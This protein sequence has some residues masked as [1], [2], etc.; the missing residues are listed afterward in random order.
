MSTFLEGVGRGLRS[1]YCSQVRSSPEWLQNVRRV[2]VPTDFRERA[3]FLNN[4]V[5]GDEGPSL[6]PPPYTGGQ[7]S[8]PYSPIATIAYTYYDAAFTGTNK[9]GTFEGI[10]NFGPFYPVN[11][12]LG[13]VTQEIATTT[14]HN[15]HLIV[16]LET[17][18]GVIF[19][20]VNAPVPAVGGKIVSIDGVSISPNSSLPDDCGDPIPP[21][22]PGTNINAPITINYG[23]SNQY[24]LTVPVLWA[25]VTV[26]LNGTVTVPVTVNISP[27]IE[28]TGNVTLF[29]DFEFKPTFNF[30]GVDS[31][32][33]DPDDAPPDDPTGDPDNPDDTSDPSDDEPSE[34]PLQRIHAV[35]C[36][37]VVQPE[38][39]PTG[40]FQP[41]GPD[42]YAP[43]LGSVRFGW[44]MNGGVFWSRDID[45]KGLS[46]VIE[47][48]FPW[49]ADRV[50]VNAAQ[51]AAINWTALY[52][53]NPP[54][55]ESFALGDTGLSDRR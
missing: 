1:A 22:G 15:D 11:G 6:A 17:A 43:R 33:F 2:L 14:Y 28:L 20:R 50:A 51:G 47:C 26:N 7:C 9:Q 35:L 18:S 39:R 23:D 46:S 55:P 8:I 49:G 42:I 13:A 16:T 5:C 19:W 27:N 24:S 34:E 53:D 12:P 10:A 29:P 37:A 3:D 30:P 38:A 21:R 32:G 31:P 45:V 4:W 25:P 44:Y 54:W 52:S 48:P 36:R 41:D 40:I